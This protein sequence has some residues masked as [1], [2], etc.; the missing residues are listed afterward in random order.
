MLGQS[1]AA[2]TVFSPGPT[3]A[4]G[5]TITFDGDYKI[6]T[7]TTVGTGSFVIQSIGEDNAFDVLVVAGGGGG[8]HGSNIA[9]FGDTLGAG[10]GGGGVIYQESRSLSTGTYQV[11]VGAGGSGNGFFTN[12]LVNGND[13]ALGTLV[14][15]GGGGGGTMYPGNQ[16]GN[17][18]G[19][20]GGAGGGVNDGGTNCGTV[21]PADYDGIATQ[22]TQSGDSGT[23]GFGTN[24]GVPSNC[25]NAPSP[26]L[27]AHYR[28]GGGGGGAGSIANLTVGGSGK[29]VS[30]T[31]TAVEYAKGGT[32]GSGLTGAA[33][34][35][36]GGA[37]DS[38]GGFTLGTGGS[39]IVV[40]RYV[41]Q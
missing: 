7:F 24:G 21:T 15:K 23:Y 31:G 3:I 25:S 1:A 4:T 9:N 20:G 14:A 34:T 40:I 10:G 29:T 39:G 6:H 2:S 22:P 38:A 8:G 37:G 41:Y 13:S 30:I 36:N 27:Y 5:G 32:A 33:N 19:S 12:P 16:K 26:P 28:D 11:I 17:D 35:G 18:G